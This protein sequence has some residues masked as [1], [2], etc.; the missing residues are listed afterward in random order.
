MADRTL[1]PENK[2]SKFSSQ[3][4]PNHHEYLRLNAGYYHATGKISENANIKVFAKP[5][6]TRVISLKWPSCVKHSVHTL[7]NT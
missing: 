1:R 4:L 3:A 6:H 7:C 2:L 5:Q